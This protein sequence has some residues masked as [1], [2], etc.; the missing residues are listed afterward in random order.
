MKRLNGAHYSSRYTLPPHTHTHACM[1][2]HPLP[3]TPNTRLLATL[4]LPSKWSWQQ[5]RQHTHTIWATRHWLLDITSLKTSECVTQLYYINF[6]PVS[7][8][9]QWCNWFRILWNESE[10]WSVNDSTGWS[11]VFPVSPLQWCLEVN[12]DFSTD[13]SFCNKCHFKHIPTYI[14]ESKHCNMWFDSGCHEC[15]V[16]SMTV[17]HEIQRMNFSESFLKTRS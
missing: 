9:L 12:V 13:L 16:N 3:W 15:D 14:L 2:A 10:S 4:L 5:M 11:Q 7:S 6:F 1:H 17:I 8:S